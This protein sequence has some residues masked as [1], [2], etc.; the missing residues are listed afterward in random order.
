MKYEYVLKFLY[1]FIRGGVEERLVS[2]CGCVL[3][4]FGVDRV[5]TSRIVG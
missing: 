3:G 5:R 4:Y 1:K 2:G